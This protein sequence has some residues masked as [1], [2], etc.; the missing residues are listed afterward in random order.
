MI[1][2]RWSGKFG[3]RLFQMSAANILSMKYNSVINNYW[4]SM[5]SI[6]EVNDAL[7]CKYYTKTITVNND[8]IKQIFNEPVK[9][10]LLIH[11]YFQ[12]RWCIEKFIKMNKYLNSYEN[13]I[14]A[15]FIH[16]RLGDLLQN[17][18]MSL[19][20]DYYKNAIEQMNNSRIIISSDSPQHEMV[21][22]LKNAYNAETY[23]G[24]VIETI[25]LGA[26]CNKKV[27]SL[28]T[29]SWWIGFLGSMFWKDQETIC[30]LK[31]R[32]IVWHGD[33]FPMFNWKCF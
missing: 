12:T 16:V 3:N 25:M 32:S 17:N 2:I 10:N 18:N 22:R 28:G 6:L 7:G 27:L 20:Y 24:S 9:A 15:T 21:H 5:D 26:N 19:P 29:F 31:S 13:Q 14:D 8:N 11:D 33:I 30:P 23:N 4:N 1:E